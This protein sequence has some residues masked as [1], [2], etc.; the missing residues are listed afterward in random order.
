MRLS[1][2]AVVVFAFG[3]RL[4][5]IIITITR[6][7][8]LTEAMHTSDFFLHGVETVICTQAVMHY[9][10]I[11]STIPC[12]KPFVISFN[13]GWGQGLASQQGSSYYKKFGLGGNRT[14]ST[15]ST[16]TRSQ[17]G[18]DSSSSS[19]ISSPSSAPPL[20][21]LVYPPR[22]I[23]S[24]PSPTPTTTTRTIQ[25]R[26]QAQTQAGRNNDVECGYGVISIDE[27]L[28]V[29]NINNDAATEIE[30]ETPV[31]N[32][33][34]ERFYS[35]NSNSSRRLI[36]MHQKSLQLEQQR[37][38]EAA[39]GAGGAGGE[40]SVSMSDREDSNQHQHHYRQHHHQDRHRSQRRGDSI[41]MVSV[42]SGKAKRL[43]SI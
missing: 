6:T 32:G 21:Q 43:F 16:T 37:K 34:S 10:L 9:S 29:D 11:A 4:A 38:K 20:K 12:L 3:S 19:V 35:L 39:G 14:S 36:L 27:V 25:G 1:S 40:D 42:K 5:V 30:A 15:R 2:K 33:S 7:V 31:L 8:Y 26:A 13:T 41:E 18:Q 17:S 22:V 23:E 24:P 28:S